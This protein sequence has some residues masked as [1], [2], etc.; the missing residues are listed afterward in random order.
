MLNMKKGLAI[1]LAAATALT[2]A[3]VSTLGLQGVVE[4]QAAE[5][6][7]IGVDQDSLTK[8]TASTVKVTALSVPE[9]I[10]NGDEYKLY[11]AKSASAL[12]TSAETATA[13][14]TDDGTADATDGMAVNAASSVITFTADRTN[15][16]KA[17]QNLLS[18]VSG[19]TTFAITPATAG[20]YYV[21]LSKKASGGTETVIGA[22]ALPCYATNS[23]TVTKGHSTVT[24][25]DSAA[26]FGK[27]ESFKVKADDGYQVDTVTY[28]YASGSDTVNKVLTADKDGNYSFTMPNVAVSVVVTT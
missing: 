14:A 19:D 17:S 12:S 8:G 23:I 2:L 7:K 25:L 24:G 26:N 10:V 18:V 4:A 1:V 27:T 20:D 13:S 6:A 5:T 11:V 21:V 9:A 28:S 16:T 3:P 22:T 15:G